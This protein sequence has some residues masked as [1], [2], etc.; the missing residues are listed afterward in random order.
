MTWLACFRSDAIS[1]QL[2]TAGLRLYQ[3]D[4]LGLSRRMSLRAPKA[5]FLLHEGWARSLIPN[6]DVA[7]LVDAR[8]LK[9]LSRKAMRVRPPPRAHSPT[10]SDCFGVAHGL[11]RRLQIAVK[12]H[13]SQADQRP[14]CCGDINAQAAHLHQA[15]GGKHLQRSQRVI[16]AMPR[17]ALVALRRRPPALSS[18]LV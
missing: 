13:G 17:I 14:P 4:R 11:L 10:P 16:V 5:S 7:E 18:G 2:V 6:A 9:S 3:G 12:A 15:I 8:D 1:K